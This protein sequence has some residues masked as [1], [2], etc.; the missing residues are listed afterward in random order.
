MTNP[1]DPPAEPDAEPSPV[2]IDSDA[3][4]HSADIV[5]WGF[6]FIWAMFIVGGL[7][8]AALAVAN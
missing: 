4:W 1:Y 8:A 2:E 5:D 3:G 6:R 7:L